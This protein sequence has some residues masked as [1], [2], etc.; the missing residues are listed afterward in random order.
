M[1]LIKGLHHVAMRCCSAEEYEKTIAF[2]RDVLGLKVERAW[3]TGTM[4]IAD[5]DIIEIFND[6][7]EH[8]DKG[9]IEHFAFA[10]DDVDGCVEAV[11]AA[12]YDVFTEP[13]DIMIDSVPKMPARIAFVHG[14]L[15]EEIEFFQEK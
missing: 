11:R 7:K 12:G 9:V 10:T 15:G 4:L 6:G 8:L 14:P 3:E 1:S 5:T 2:Y 13:K